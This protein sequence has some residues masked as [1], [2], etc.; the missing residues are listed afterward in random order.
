[1]KKTLIE[2]IKKARSVIKKSF[3]VYR[4]EKTVIAWTGGKDSTVLLHLVKETFKG[5]VPFPVMFND[6]TMEFEEIYEFIKKITKEWSLNLIVIHHNEKELTQFHKTE[7]KAEKKKLSR[8]M[9]VS[10]INSFL[11]KYPVQAIMAGIRWD[12]HVSRSKETYFSSRDDHIRVHPLLDFTETDIWAYIEAYKVP[13]VSLYD[14]GYRSLGE[15]PFTKKATK[16]G[17]ERSGRE[18]DKEQLMDKLRNIG[19]W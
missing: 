9:K 3:K 1:M 8:M 5:V 10:A 19:Y 17:D 4:P 6:S 18:K 7:N 11:H 13:Y 14:K 2:K 12:E 15:K 16:Y